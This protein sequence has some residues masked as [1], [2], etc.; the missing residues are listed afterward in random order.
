MVFECFERDIYR[1]GMVVERI[2][3]I[4]EDYFGHLIFL[5]Q[6]GTKVITKYHK[7]SLCTFVRTLCPLC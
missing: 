3:K 5:T 4:E 7:D 6:R 2:V 1:G